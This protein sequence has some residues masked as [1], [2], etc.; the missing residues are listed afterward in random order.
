[1]AKGSEGVERAPERVWALGPSDFAFLWAECRACF[2]RKI[3]LR[4]TRPRSPFPKV[5]GVIDR[6]MKD[7]CLGERGDK[8]ADGGPPGVIGSPNRWVKSAPLLVGTPTPI[9]IRGLVDVLVD[10]DDSTTGVIDLKT[11]ETNDAHTALYG[12][13]LHAY[14]TALEHPSSGRPLE[15]SALGLLCFSPSD[16]DANGERAALFGRLKWTEIPRDDAAFVS[17]LAEVGSVLDAPEP[18]PGPDCEWCALRSQIDPPNPA[19]SA[20]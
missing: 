11:A 18:L 7:F 6:A 12:R 17:F 15:V 14:A 19:A 5:F 1:M 8:L 4:Q 2:Y 9:V 3:V 10:C 20:A 16:F 13:Q